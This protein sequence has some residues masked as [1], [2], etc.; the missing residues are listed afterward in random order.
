[1]QSVSGLFC[2]ASFF[3]FVLSAFGRGTKRMTFVF[4]FVATI[5]VGSCVR[6]GIRQH[7]PSA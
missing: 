3:G 6:G 7:Q 4:C 5:R 2:R 1:M